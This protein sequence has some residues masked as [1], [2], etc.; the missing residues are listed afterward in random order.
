[1]DFS[2]D[3]QTAIVRDTARKFLLEQCP[4]SRVREIL[5]TEEG[6]SPEMWKKMANL[7][8]LGLVNEEAYGGTGADLLDLFTLLEEMGRA[9]LPS[10][11]FSSAVIAGLL[12]EEAADQVMKKALLPQMIRGEG[13]LTVA[14]LDERGLADFDDPTLRA[15]PVEGDGYEL[16]G[17]RLLVPFAHVAGGILVCAKIEGAVGAGPTL[18]LADPKTQGL[19]RLPLDILTK[20]RT[21][22]L[23]FDGARVDGDRM[24]GGPG[25]GGAHVGRIWPKATVLKCAE[26][27]GGMERVVEMTVAYVKERHQFGRPL[28]ALQAVHHACFEMATCLE[29][30]R[31]AATQAVWLLAQGLPAAKEV[32]IAKAWCNDA[33]KKCSAVGHQLHGAIGF[34]E[35]H[36]MHLYSQHAKASEMA[37]GASWL[38]RSRIADELGI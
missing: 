6:Y 38:H 5:A 36:D 8:W 4:S 25:R 16:T 32:A 22:A 10:P 26:M 14:L 30:T 33:Y 23:R 20:E 37:F 27:L 13:I 2:P 15:H 17:A 11:F 29:T 1:M 21:F 3:E 35:E 28:G 31:L 24:I 18:F 34:T 19:E 7:G 12:I 9:Q